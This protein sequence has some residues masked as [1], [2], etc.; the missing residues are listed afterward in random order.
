MARGSR[1]R[2]STAP[3]GG[4]LL[5]KPVGITSR[6]A[7]EQVEK[8]LGFGPLGHTGTLDPLAS[9]LLLLL[10]GE[11]RKFQ[12]LLTGHDK[13]YQATV[14][15]GVLSGSEDGEG[16]LHSRWPRP[17][18]PTGSE[19][20]GALDLFRGGYLQTPPVRSAIRISGERSWRREQAGAPLTPP[21]RE[22]RIDSIEVESFR[23]PR[24]ELEVACGSGTYVRSL[25]RD[26][27]AELGSGGY[28]AGL[29]RVSLGVHQ[30]QASIPLA[31]VDGECWLSLEALLKKEPRV[32][33][34]SEVAER[35]GHGQVVP[36]EGEGERS[37]AHGDRV[38]WSEGKVVGLIRLDGPLL[39]PA[40]W[41]NP[42]PV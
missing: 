38:V 10:G 21:A 2:H 19:L 16:P 29:S 15:L 28:L 3:S 18:M 5:W 27:G 34:T 24:V 20:E 8:T 7:L 37:D 26:I 17:S 25:A 23:P 13:V 40:R 31:E 39:R 9:G 11:G 33:V 42:D 32:E 30:Q 14:E 41:L 6:D 36:V 35:L 1:W 4:L 12:S 22:V